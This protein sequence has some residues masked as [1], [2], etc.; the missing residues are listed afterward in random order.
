MCPSWH[1]LMLSV[2]AHDSAAKKIKFPDRKPMGSWASRTLLGDEASFPRNRDVSPAPKTWRPTAWWFV[3][4][5]SDFRCV[6]TA[7]SCF[8][9]KVPSWLTHKGGTVRNFAQCT[10]LFLVKIHQFSTWKWPFLW[11]L[12]RHETCRSITAQPRTS[13]SSSTTCQ[14]SRASYPRVSKRSRPLPFWWGFNQERW[15]WKQGGHNVFT[16]NWT[17][18]SN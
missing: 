16:I 17:S 9:I 1:F 11:V 8:Y 13:K 15:Q 3:P 7:P 4:R 18:E 12:V 14:R 10:H 2:S 6:F 5:W